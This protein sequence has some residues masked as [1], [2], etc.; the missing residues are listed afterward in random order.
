MKK[1]FTII[2]SIIAIIINFVSVQAQEMAFAAA[3]PYILSFNPPLA[4]PVNANPAEALDLTA[5]GLYELPTEALVSNAE[6]IKLDSNLMDIINVN[7]CQGS[8]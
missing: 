2:A 8:Q 1:Q 6:V 4:E 7:G 5:Q 3:T